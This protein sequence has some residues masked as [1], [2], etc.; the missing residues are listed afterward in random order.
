MDS[1]TSDKTSRKGSLIPLS[2]HPQMDRLVE[3][4]RDLPAD[5]Q[6]AFGEWLD[7]RITNN[8]EQVTHG[9]NDESERVD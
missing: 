9:E 1:Q 6:E 2:E 8:G 3:I 5:R 7:E 4:L